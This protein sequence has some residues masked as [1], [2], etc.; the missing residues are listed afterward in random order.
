[1]LGEQSGASH[2]HCSLRKSTL[3]DARKRAHD[4][5][6]N[7]CLLRG[8]H[9][10]DR[11]ALNHMADLVAESSRQL[12]QLS[13]ALNEPSIDVDIPAGQSEGVHLLGVHDVE[14]PI[15]V[16]SA[17][18]IG[19]RVA[20]VLDVSTDGRIGY[21]RQLR[22]DF[23]GVLPAQSDFLILRYGAGREDRNESERD[24]RTNH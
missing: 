2:L 9:L 20:E 10:L 6:S 12:V 16:R 4:G 24:E 14:M 23:L 3:A 22:V 17:G 18:G 8:L 21:D 5:D 1:V 11:V 13:C 19:N 15:Q 7:V